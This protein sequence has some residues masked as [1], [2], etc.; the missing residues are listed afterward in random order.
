M[1]SQTSIVFT[2]DFAC[3]SYMKDRWMDPCFFDVDIL[4]FFHSAD[5]VAVN[6]EGAFYDAQ[7]GSDP[8][9]K[10]RFCHFQDPKSSKILKDIGADIWCIANNHSMDMK[11]PGLEKTTSLAKECGAVTIGAGRNIEEA[12]KPV[13]LDE[14]GGI[15]IIAVGYLPECLP[16][17][18][19][20]AGNFP[21]ND[22][23]RI[24]KIIKEIKKTC[25]WCVVVSHGGEEFANLP[26][27]Y[28]RERYL[29]FLEFGAD[30]VIGHHP[31]V[32]QN[33][34]TVG[35]KAIFYSLGNFVF[36]TD[37]QRQRYNT[38]VG[39]LLKL[40]FSE[41]DLTFLPYGIKIN[42]DKP[43]KEAGP[44]PD[45][46]SDIRAVEYEKLSPLSAKAFIEMEKKRRMF[47]DPQKY[48]CYKTD[49]EWLGFFKK[50]C[51]VPKGIMDFTH[52]LPLV[53][54]YNDKE[55]KNSSLKAV[56]D[57]ILKQL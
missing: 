44:P 6:V 46:S 47:I 7:E 26:H 20:D 3:D 8:S 48:K 45:I 55:W 36:D 39:V 34:E 10:G 24:E 13:Y 50:T 42:R 57:Y 18:E 1:K 15:G 40:T 28:I 30:V 17:T 43:R 37:Y 53:E 41:T 56:K 23:E 19:T 32:A 38:D 9:G 21:M 35:I 11:L 5:H 12:S 27:P 33:Y 51:W 52:I 16:A 54:R 49:E 31:H 14:A 22:T 25:R 29:Q 4:K 2:G